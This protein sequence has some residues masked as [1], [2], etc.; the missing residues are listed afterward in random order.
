[1]MRSLQDLSAVRGLARRKRRWV[2]LGL[3]AALLAQGCLGAFGLTL[4][5]HIVGF[6]ALIVALKLRRVDQSYIDFMESM[7]VELMT[8]MGNMAAM[9]RRAQAEHAE[10]N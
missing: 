8:V 6:T 3:L 4:W 5:A 10:P 2:S 1:M 9:D 7:S